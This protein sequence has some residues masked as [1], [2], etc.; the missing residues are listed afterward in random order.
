MGKVY[1]VVVI[2]R[3]VVTFDVDNCPSSLTDNLKNN[4]LVLREG[5]TDG[6]NDSI[7]AIQK[8]LVLTL[9]K[10]TF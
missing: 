3:N 10:F 1:G 9:A 2:T 4:V 6:I 7:G 5:L 8:Y